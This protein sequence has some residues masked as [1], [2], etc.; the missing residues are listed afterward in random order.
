MLFTVFVVSFVFGVVWPGLDAVA[1]LAVFE[2]VTDVASAVHMLIS[3]SALCFVLN[4]LSFVDV[5]V[6][7]DKPAT[8]VSLVVLPVANVLASVLP[9]LRASSLSFAFLG[10]LPLIDGSVVQLIRSFFNQRCVTRT[11]LVEHK[12]TN[13]LFSGACRL[14]GVIRHRLQLFGE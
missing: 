6:T 7:M 9:D 14:V 4:P 2:P 1:V 8:A 12:W 5:T 10:P 3:P 11:V 13:A